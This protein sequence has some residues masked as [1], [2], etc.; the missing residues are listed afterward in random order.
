[1]EHL[2]L[3]PIHVVLPVQFEPSRI[4][5]NYVLPSNQRISEVIGHKKYQ[6]QRTVWITRHLL[7]M[8]RD[9]QNH[10]RCPQEQ[11]HVKT[12]ASM[13]REYFDSY[14]D[15]SH[16]LSDVRDIPYRAWKKR[17]GGKEKGRF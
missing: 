11:G 7:L 6:R 2:C 13:E 12:I 10:L 3:Y 9:L 14:K 16:T 15:L 5:A 8:F 4:L 1:M 17:L